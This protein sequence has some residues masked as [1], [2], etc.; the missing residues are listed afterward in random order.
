[1]IQ[2]VVIKSGDNR[3]V[4]QVIKELAIAHKIAIAIFDVSTFWITYLLQRNLGAMLDLIQIV[5]L[6]AK[7]FATRFRSPTTRQRIEWT[8]PPYFDYATYYNYVRPLTNDS[9]TGICLTVCSSYFTLLLRCVSP[10]SSL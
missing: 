1:M 7:S 4:W 10:L 6:V 5:P 2:D 9:I 8:A 3:D